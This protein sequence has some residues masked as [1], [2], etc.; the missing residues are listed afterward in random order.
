MLSL[1]AADTL[2][3]PETVAPSAGAV[4]DTVGAVVSV[5]SVVPTVTL[6]VALVVRLPAASRARADN[7]WD[8]VLAS[9]LSHAMA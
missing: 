9:V 3:I 2:T 6:T 8:P 1:A 5:G 7:V 4:I